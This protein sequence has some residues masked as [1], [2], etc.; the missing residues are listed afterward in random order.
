MSVNRAKEFQNALMCVVKVLPEFDPQM[1]MLG[2][3]SDF[4]KRNDETH[5]A[6]LR[7]SP[8]YLIACTRRGTMQSRRARGEI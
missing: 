6:V 8:P 3:I 7:S 5:G 1:L 2:R 4:Y